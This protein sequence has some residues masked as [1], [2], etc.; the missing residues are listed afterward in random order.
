M[1]R[2]GLCVI[3]TLIFVVVSSLICGVMFAKATEQVGVTLSSSI[4]SRE[5]I[6]AFACGVKLA[7]DW[8]LSSIVSGDVP[9]RGMNGHD[10]PL[11]SIEALRSDGSGASSDLAARFGA[12]FYVAD[13]DY[14]EGLFRG[15]SSPIQR[16]T[17][18]IPRIPEI[19]S[20]DGVLRYY[21]LRSDA[22]GARNARVIHEE[23]VSVKLD[24]LGRVTDVRRLFSR[25]RA[26]ITSGEFEKIL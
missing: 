21:Y 17:P 8:L 7:E 23:L 2:R 1:R 12:S 3:P 18:S 4:R 16:R 25:S 5:S 19:R 26:E 10:T 14:D 22:E 9:R 11:A 24:H 13:V 6:E 15:S 20:S